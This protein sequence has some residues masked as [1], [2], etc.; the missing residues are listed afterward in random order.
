[1]I[2]KQVEWRQLGDSVGVVGGDLVVGLGRDVDD[3]G[4]VHEVEFEED[5]IAEGGE[6]VVR[7]TEGVAEGWEG[8]WVGSGEVDG[9]EFRITLQVG[10]AVADASGVGGRAEA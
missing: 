10:P 9:G 3:G 4:L 1:M 2:G 7:G 6:V 8:G 5:D